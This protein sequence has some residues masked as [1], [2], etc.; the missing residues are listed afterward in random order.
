MPAF[1]LLALID[2]TLYIY[3]HFADGRTLPAVIALLFIPD[4]SEPSPF[5]DGSH[6]GPE[7]AEVAAPDS[8]PH[9]AIKGQPQYQLKWKGY[10]K[11]VPPGHVF[12][13]HPD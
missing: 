10:A 12:C 8:S 3:A 6:Y 9:R 1:E 2:K 7:R 5:R 4:Y 13:L 11:K